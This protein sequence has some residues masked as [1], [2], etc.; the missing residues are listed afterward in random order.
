MNSLVTHVCFWSRHPIARALYLIPARKVLRKLSE[1]SRTYE[2]DTK[3]RTSCVRDVPWRIKI[4]SIASLSY[5]L[6]VYSFTQANFNSS[7][8]LKLLSNLYKSCSSWI[9]FTA[10]YC[11]KQVLRLDETWWNKKNSSA[12]QN[13]YWIVKETKIKL[14]WNADNFFRF[15]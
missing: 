6:D 2:Q 3:S 9:C 13:T 4:T 11:F 10:A 15:R 7:K 12:A 1:L 8:F 14:F 5:Q